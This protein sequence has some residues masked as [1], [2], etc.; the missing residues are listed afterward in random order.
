MNLIIVD[1]R[2]GITVWSSYVRSN[3]EWI[4]NRILMGFVIAPIEALPE[5]TVTDVVS[6]KMA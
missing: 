5:I 4:A 1:R 3:G 2:Q 6:I